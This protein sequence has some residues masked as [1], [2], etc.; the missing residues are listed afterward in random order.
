MLL[1]LKLFF[2]ILRFQIPIDEREFKFQQNI[3]RIQLPSVCSNYNSTNILLKY[4]ARQIMQL[5]IYLSALQNYGR[6]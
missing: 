2:V 4:D 1:I 3:L 5:T 6:P